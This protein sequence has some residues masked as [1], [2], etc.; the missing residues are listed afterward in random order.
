MNIGFVGLGKLGLPVALAV[1]SKGHSVAGY[2]PA[3]R[4]RGVI[5]SRKL[6]YQERGAQELLEKSKIR[7]ME[8]G[9]LVEWSDIVFV[10]VQTP[11]EHEYEGVTRLPDERKGFYYGYL[12]DAIAAISRAVRGPKVV[13][14]ISTVLPG[15]VESRIKP[16]MHP[17]I[18]L[19]Y[20]PFFIAMGTTI[21]DFLSPEFVLLGVDDEEAAKVVERFYATVT[22]AKVFRTDIKTAELIKVAYN[23]WISTKVSV[24]N[25]LMEV[26]EKVGADVDDVSDALALATRRIVSPAYTRA[27]MG[28]GGA[29]HPRDNIALSELARRIGLSY[30]WYES[31]M[32]CRERQ[33]EWLAELI[34]REQEIRNLPVVLLGIAFKPRTNITAGSAAILLSNILLEKRRAT[35]H[36]MYDPHVDPPFREIGSTRASALN[37]RDLVD[38]LKRPAVFFVSTKHPEWASFDFP[39]GS[40]VLD[41]HGY[42]SDKPGVHVVRIGRR[43]T[44]S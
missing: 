10:A 37:P 6:N 14:V 23:T 25:T 15:T 28:D 9:E 29:C 22:D 41:P 31:I 7:L 1:E 40:V 27:G 17:M 39:V 2:D 8:I 18:K 12:E 13:S 34:I 26:C 5:E 24:A 44:R 16:V 32:I 19:C 21:M 11:H 20:N 43:R 42:I 30:D 38:S 33:T 3:Q 4:A 36:L 35:P